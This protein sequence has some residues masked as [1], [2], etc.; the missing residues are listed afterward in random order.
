MN[1][2]RSRSIRTLIVT[3]TIVGAAIGINNAASAA[4][5]PTPN[6]TANATPKHMVTLL[7][8]DR[9]AVFQSGGFVI[10]RAP[11]RENIDFFTSQTA[12]QLRVVPSD[13]IKLLQ[14]GHLDERLFNVTEL[15]KQG[16]DDRRAGLP[17]IVG[18]GASD[19]AVATATSKVSG[20]AASDVRALPRVHMVTVQQRRAQANRFWV[21]LT[22]G[23]SRSR[24]LDSAVSKVWLDTKGHV[25]LDRSAP[26]IG[27]PAAW[28]TGYTGKG[29]SVAVLDTGADVSHPD[30]AGQIAATRNFTA[31]AD[32]DL[33]G[34]GT[35]VSS[36]VAG[37]G[38]G[39]SGRYRGVAPEARLVVGKVCDQYGDCAES[40]VIAGME[41]AA[42][43]EQAKVIS[44]S[45]GWPD[46][47]GLTPQEQAV[48]TLSARFGTLFVAAAGN[49]GEDG[50]VNRPA[51]APSALAVAAVDRSDA[52][53]SFSSR[54]PRRGDDGLKPE[55]SAPG[56]EIMAA[57]SQQAGTPGE[58]YTTMSG[59]SMATPHVAGAAALLAQRYPEWTGQR[60]KAA[61]MA[62]AIPN[63][64]VGVF[65][66]GAGRVDVARAV[67][68]GLIAQPAS[69]GFDRPHY[70][71]GDDQPMSSL[72]TYH[73]YGTTAVTL[74]LSISGTVAAI[75]GESGV[76]APNGMLQVSPDSVTVPAGGDASVTVTADTSISSPDG[77]VGGYLT[78][79]GDELTVRTPVA[80]NKEVE[81]YDLT[82]TH[83]NRTGKATGEF[84][85]TLKSLDGNRSYDFYESSNGVTTLRVPKGS[86]VLTSAISNASDQATS[87]QAAAAASGRDVSLLVQPR[88]ELAAD[89]KLTVDARVAR[90]AAADV[91]VPEGKASLVEI[92]AGWVQTTSTGWFSTSVG[93]GDPNSLYTGQ[94]RGAKS[95]AGFTSQI[96]GLWGE[97][98]GDGEFGQKFTVNLAWYANGTMIR[99]KTHRVRAA[100]LA[101]VTAKYASSLPRSQGIGG[102]LPHAPGKRPLGGPGLVISLPATVTEYYNTDAGVEWT[103]SLVEIAGD[104]EAFAITEQPSARFEAG[105]RYPIDLN[106]GVF[107]PTVKAGEAVRRTGDTL[108]I[109]LPMFGDGAGN[110]GDSSATGF[111][112]LR[113]NGAII[114]MSSTP[115]RL[116]FKVSE[117]EKRHEVMAYARRT[118]PFELSTEV[119]GLWS[120][121]SSH[122][123]SA[124]P[125]P[126]WTIGFAPNLSDTNTALAG[127]DLVV[128]L[129]LE[130]QPGATV[131]SLDKIDVE[132]S[133]DDGASW[134]PLRVEES[135]QG[136]EGGEGPNPANCHEKLV[137]VPHPSE[138]GFVSFRVKA[139]DSAGNTV[140][141]TILHAYR[142]VK[143]L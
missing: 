123:T 131:G 84:F 43:V 71:H 118:A 109:A 9:V 49:D 110:I 93:L 30:L 74:R 108:S 98:T 67:T 85:T 73:N 106:R 50:T 14:S 6:P 5:T 4:P 65:A 94:I 88:L 39:S 21:R 139:A 24:T 63:P 52:L 53:A 31:E 105:R 37:T 86:Y 81:S 79:T 29:V 134:Q 87:G 70:P 57:R 61:L 115:G 69:V 120:F 28:E 55:I 111:A 34:H 19:E 42:G 80:V 46:A 13:A 75:A 117:S 127:R 128:P 138:P 122:T 107:G 25:L 23:N 102:A 112:M 83:L 133:F 36:T 135:G 132:V 58:L 104:F 17:L 8:G 97:K 27:A 142:L 114:A 62:T 116:D 124:T 103:P 141:E 100:D 48:E 129:R 59:T 90:K 89:Q 44:M 16:Y 99:G 101:V 136:G 41:W 119:I 60:L 26:Q 121:K 68:A 20:E 125:M 38:A 51:S 40:D 18:A 35:H 126:L 7:T 47:P 54:G 76:A 32:G 45:L 130:S 22:G 77:Y 78:A 91:T 95:S 113:E 1:R 143:A 137:T 11:N 82:L 66:Q 15:I 33:H 92:S 96:N 2:Q 10:S 72:V 64:K 56:V 140:D 12:G 3:M